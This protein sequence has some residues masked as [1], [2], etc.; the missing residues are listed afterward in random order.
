MTEEMLKKNAIIV[1]NS[2]IFEN[3]LKSQ[4]RG[5]GYVAKNQLRYA[6]GLNENDQLLT[7]IE[8]WKYVIEEI[9]EFDAETA[10]AYL[11]DSLVKTLKLDKTIPLFGCGIKDRTRP[12]YSFILQFLYPDK[13]KEYENEHM[14]SICE[15]AKKTKIP[16]A[17]SHFWSQ[18]EYE[19]KTRKNQL[20]VEKLKG[21][22][23]NVYAKKKIYRG[24]E[25]AIIC[26][27]VII[28]GHLIGN[29]STQEMYKL[30][31]DE[32]RA[33]KLINEYGQIYKCV[34]PKY[35]PTALDYFHESLRPEDRNDFWYMANKIR[36]KLQRLSE[37][38][39]A[40]FEF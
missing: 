35:F 21:K 4:K 24:K 16:I 6:L 8:I 2:M 28:Y 30:F 40:G 15:H 36:N 18:A 1:Y 26:M 17:P 37:T 14:K 13:I 20:V 31:S 39:N 25:N 7:G 33:S 10:I 32:K 19:E 29:H 23:N 38:D 22:C 3:D 27:R 9:L 12:G 5:N 34:I 11:D